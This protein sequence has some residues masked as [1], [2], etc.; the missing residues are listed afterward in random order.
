MVTVYDKVA[1][2]GY[3]VGEIWYSRRCTGNICEEGLAYVYDLFQGHGRPRCPHGSLDRDRDDE[4][5]K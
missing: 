4:R 2:G 5:T 1:G 3:E